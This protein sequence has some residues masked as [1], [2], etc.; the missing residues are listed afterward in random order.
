MTTTSA[1]QPSLRS[2]LLR[3]MGMNP[4][5]ADQAV[6]ALI[7]L[8]PMIVSFGIFYI[9]PL[10]DGF[11][12]S[13]TDW[14]AFV[15][16]REFQGFDN[17]QRLLDDRVFL[18]ALRNTF[19]YTLYYLPLAIGLALGAALAIEN[20]GRPREFF[21]TAYF[22]P[23]VTSVIA[24]ALIFKWLYQPQ[25]GLFNQLLRMA[26]LPRQSFL[27]SIDQ[28]LPSIAAY[29]IWK[30]LGFNMVLFMAGLNAIAPVYYEAARVDGANKWQQFRHITLP[31]LRPTFIFVFITGIISSL[32]VFGPIFVMSSASNNDPPGGPANSTVVVSVHQWQTAFRQLELGYGATMGIVLF[33]IIL[34]I[35]LTQVRLLRN[36]WDA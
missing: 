22:L 24:T 21:R 7:V 10:I 25:F 13:L 6:F 4:R 26:D 15:P 33:A 8:V 12:G 3:R 23:V 30:N 14:R 27:N 36:R 32:Q 9:Y 17:Y 28:A 5:N 2:R 19:L 18:A 11:W 20:S 31:L 16:T 29:A 1:T 34:L 35:T